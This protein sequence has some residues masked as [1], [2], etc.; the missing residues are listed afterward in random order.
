[1]IFILLCTSTPVP[2]PNVNTVG[3]SLILS[4]ATLFVTFFLCV[5]NIFLRK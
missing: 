5:C 3:Q 4:A 2:F 1:M